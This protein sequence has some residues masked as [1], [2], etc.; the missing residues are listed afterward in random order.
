MGNIRASKSDDGSYFISFDLRANTAWTSDEWS[1]SSVLIFRAVRGCRDIREIFEAVQKSLWNAP[2]CVGY[3]SCQSRIS[4]RCRRSSYLLRV[5]SRKGL[6][7]QKSAE[8]LK[9]RKLKIASSLLVLDVLVLRLFEYLVGLTCWW[10][11][12]LLSVPNSNKF[13]VG[14]EVFYIL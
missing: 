6:R 4:W 3:S 7:R 1:G 5:Q 2:C 14:L 12:Q 8:H 9:V 10:E 11:S 13:T